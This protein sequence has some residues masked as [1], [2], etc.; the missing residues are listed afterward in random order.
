MPMFY[1]GLA[2]FV[3]GSGLNVTCINMML[4][5]LFTYPL[6][7]FEGVERT[8]IQLVEVFVNDGE[9]G[10]HTAGPLLRTFLAKAR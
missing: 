10:S 6:D 1:L 2:S 7:T 4:T 5:P 3:T 9:S 8:T